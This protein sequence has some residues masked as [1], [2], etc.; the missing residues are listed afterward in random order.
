MSFNQ[1][2]LKETV[3][4]Y[5]ED[6]KIMRAQVAEFLEKHFK[7]VIVAEDG[8]D[9]FNKFKEHQKEIDV[10]V[11]DIIM[12]NMTGIEMLTKIREEDKDIPCI[13]ATSVIEPNVF[14]EAIDLHVS[15]YAVKPIDFEALLSTLIEV[16]NIVHNKKLLG[17]KNDTLNKYVDAINGV[18]I[19]TK[20]DLKGNITYA[21]RLFCE[22]S[23][24]SL[25]ELMG[26]SHNIVRHPDVDK[27]VYAQMWEQIQ[28]GQ[29][30]KGIIKNIAKDGSTYFVKSHVFPLYDDFH[31]ICEYMG[32]RIVVTEDENAKRDFKKAVVQNITQ[33]R[34]T[35][36]ELRKENAKLLEENNKLKSMSKLG[37][38]DKITQLE[39]EVIKYKKESTKYFRILQ[40][41]GLDFGL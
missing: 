25:N 29:S 41:N 31:N 24:Y 28:N 19:V 15:G 18:A 32:V 23:Q 21:N 6:S 1:D 40:K 20:T 12:P 36:A 4:L 35:E 33:N 34:Q 22:V 7:K 11:S 2:L 17:Q 5:A 27:K 3:V 10:I 37:N 13:L 9:G 39:L 38:S 30:W 16:S 14:V 8:Q 26:A